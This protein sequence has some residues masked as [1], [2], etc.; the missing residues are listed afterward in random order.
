MSENK[1][2]LTEAICAAAVVPEGKTEFRLW[3]VKQPGLVLRIGRR[4]RTWTVIYRVDG[5]GRSRAPQTVTIGTF[6]AVSVKDARKAAKAR[7]GEVAKGQDPAAE[8][9]EKRRKER[10]TLERALSDYEEAL[11]ARRVVKVKEMMSTLRRGL[12]GMEQRDMGELEL[13]DCLAPVEKLEAAG[14]PGAAHD[15]RKIFRSLLAWAQSTG[16]VKYNVLSG[17]RRQRTTRA[18]QIEKETLGKALEDAELRS[19]WS[20][21]DPATVFGRYVRFLLASGCRRTEAAKLTWAMVKE[22]RIA[23]PALLMKQGREHSIPITPLVREILEACPR[24]SSELVFASPRSGGAM[25]GW[26]KI[27]PK[28]RKACGVQFN[29]HDC[30][31]TVRTG[32][33]R[34]GVDSGLAEFALG[35]QPAELIRIYD[36]ADRWP[37]RVAAFERW[38]G[39][40]SRVVTAKEVDNVFAFVPARA[41]A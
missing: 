16:R 20:A 19:V 33:T 25:V 14:M 12:K 34:L 24:T 11:V 10:A 28:F 5:A 35:H 9:R 36:R 26:S 21:A 13:R 4:S 6:P 32:F 39:H 29:L 1:L 27:V 31:R 37:E 22:D 18:Q 41:T 40:I 7:M 15:L 2:E 30:R 3:D 38:H 8:L 23:L 17:I